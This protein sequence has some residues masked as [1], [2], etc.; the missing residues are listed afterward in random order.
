MARLERPKVSR[1]PATKF[2][3]WKSNDKCFEF[4]DKEKGQ[5][6]KV[7]LPLKFLFLEHYHTVKGWAKKNRSEE[8]ECAIYSNEVYSVQHEEISVK[9][10][11]APKQIVSG[12]YKE[13]KDKIKDEGGVYYRSIYAMLE[14][15]SIVNFQLKGCAVASYYN[16]YNPIKHLLDTQWVEINSAKDAKNGMVKYSIPIFTMGKVI[17]GEI[18]QLANEAAK[19]LQEYMNEYMAKGNV[20]QK[21]DTLEMEAEETD[22][23]PIEF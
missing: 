11:K 15:G 19:V 20:L 17:S 2:L 4:Y 22:F 6:V 16:F 5:K 13:I 3:E 12:F 14:D 23:E 1:N 21:V 8:N 18:D 9:A 7:E 10:F